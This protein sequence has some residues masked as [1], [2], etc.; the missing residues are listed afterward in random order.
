MRDS[1]K[2]RFNSLGEFSM[3]V[4]V[5]GKHIDVGESLNNYITQEIE[6]VVMK[7][8]GE[9]TDS[10]AIISSRP[11]HQ[12]GAEILINI[13]HGI[14]L[15]SQAEAGDPYAATDLAVDKISRQLRK[16]KDRL[17]DHHRSQ[18]ERYEF[19]SHALDYTLSAEEDGEKKADEAFENVNGQPLVIAESTTTIPNITVKEAAMRLDLEDSNVILFKNQATDK[20]NVVYRREDG[21]IGWLEPK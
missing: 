21:N 3:I 14:R 10:S 1:Q 17:K 11:H 19:E 12:Y 2:S 13:G 20:F 6:K 7:H 4:N 5:A 15:K 9:G 16:Y 18:A 8:F